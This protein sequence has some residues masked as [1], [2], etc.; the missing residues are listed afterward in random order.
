MGENT[1][2]KTNVSINAANT[3]LKNPTVQSQMDAVLKNK[4]T[5]P[6][7]YAVVIGTNN[8]TYDVTAPN[9]GTASQ[10]VTPVWNLA[11][12]SSFLAPR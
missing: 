12:S 8:G 1:C 7:E 5:E 4:A 11:N 9:P 10:S 6:P 2:R 3:V